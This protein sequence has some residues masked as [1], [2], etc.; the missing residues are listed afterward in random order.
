MR[1]PFSVRIRQSSFSIEKDPLFDKN[2]RKAGLVQASAV[3]RYNCS[4]ISGTS[5]SV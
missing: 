4:E 2:V 1:T 5:I 3:M